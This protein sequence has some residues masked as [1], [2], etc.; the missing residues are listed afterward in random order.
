MS[1]TQTATI[2]NPSGAGQHIIQD[3]PADY[4]D[5]YAFC[6]TILFSV[7][8]LTALGYKIWRELKK[9]IIEFLQ[10]LNTNIKGYLYEQKH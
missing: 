9:D 6:G 8:I 7:I 10:E 2:Q 3:I 5:V 1:Q 4:T